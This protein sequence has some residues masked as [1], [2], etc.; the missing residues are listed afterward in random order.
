MSRLNR[1]LAILTALA[2]AL[3]V[4]ALPVAATGDV[5]HGNPVYVTTEAIE[6]AGYTIPAGFVTDLASIPVAL[7]GERMR[8]DGPWWRAA[9]LHDWLYVTNAVPRAEADR[10]FLDTLRADGVRAAARVPMFLMVRAFGGNAYRCR[11]GWDTSCA[12]VAP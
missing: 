2:T 1:T 7:Q 3:P 11:T 12:G 9:V 6:A 5:V 10:L 8:P 4:G